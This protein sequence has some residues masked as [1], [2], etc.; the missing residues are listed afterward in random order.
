MATELTGLPQ[1]PKRRPIGAGW[2]KIVKVKGERKAHAIG[3]RKPR[4]LK[5]ANARGGRAWQGPRFA[6]GGKRAK[7]YGP[8]LPKGFRRLRRKRA[9]NPQVAASNRKRARAQRV[10]KIAS[11]VPR[12]KR[13]NFM[14]LWRRLKRLA[15]AAKGGASG[16]Q[17]F[18]NHG[19]TR[20]GRGGRTG[21]AGFQSPRGRLW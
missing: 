16:S 17:A 13:F 6:H 7:Q 11:Y 2:L 14:A 20:S 10:Q 21:R 9:A 15:S 18:R 5:R 8:K 3:P 1:P 12:G 4:G 19:F